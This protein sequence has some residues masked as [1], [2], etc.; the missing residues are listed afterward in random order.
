MNACGGHERSIAMAGLRP[1]LPAGIE[2]VPSPGCPVYICPAEAAYQAIRLALSEKVIL[3]AFGE[4]FGQ[5][6]PAVIGA[7]Q[8]PAAVDRDWAEHDWTLLSALRTARFWWI[9]SGYCCGMFTW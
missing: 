4:E 5:P 9:A 7:E 1:A 8:V 3:V 2:L 6:Y